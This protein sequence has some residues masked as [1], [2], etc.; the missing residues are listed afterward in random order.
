MRLLLLLVSSWAVLGLALA[1]SSYNYFRLPTALRP[2]KYNLRVLTHLED[3]ENLR[4]EGNVKI[5]FKALENTKNITLHSKNLTIDNSLITLRDTSSANKKYC[6]SGT[7]V[8]PA[9]D[10]FV[11]RI[12]EELVAGQV[13]ELTMPFAADLN[14]Q[15]EGY[16]R[17]SYNDPE[18]NKTR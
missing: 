2:L 15:L 18:T 3:P 16:Y 10:F 9:H 11:M 7:E 4:F 6:F 13:Y 14:R 17:S 5:L 8:I 12:C 1:D